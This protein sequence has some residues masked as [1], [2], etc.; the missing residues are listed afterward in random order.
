LII[1]SGWCWHCLKTGRPMVCK[2]IHHAGRTH[3]TCRRRTDLCNRT[4]CGMD[5][6][7]SRRTMSVLARVR[8]IWYLP[9]KI[10]LPVGHEA[11]I[12][13]RSGLAAK[14]S[15]TVLNS[16]GTIDADYRG[17]IKASHQPRTNRFY[18]Y[19]RWT[20]RTNGRRQVWSHESI[21]GQWTRQD[22]VG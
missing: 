11:Q 16:P 21:P 8:R 2:P 18:H 1:A 9:V 17:E 15:V 6:R 10:A 5:C 12:R 4:Q 19:E 20:N 7:R 3:A 22:F 13:P 14:Q